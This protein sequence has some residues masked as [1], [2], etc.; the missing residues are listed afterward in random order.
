MILFI[1]L[2]VPVGWHMAALSTNIPWIGW[3]ENWIS[4]VPEQMIGV[5]FVHLEGLR[6]KIRRCQRKKCAGRWVLSR[7]FLFTS[8]WLLFE[9]RCLS[10]RDLRRLCPRDLRRLSPRSIYLPMYQ[11]IPISS[12]PAIYLSRYLPIYL[13]TYL[14]M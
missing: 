14:A 10:P 11:P 6:K 7:L 1:A 8:A 5:F 2:G 4:H 9:A 13:S 12:Y 3:S